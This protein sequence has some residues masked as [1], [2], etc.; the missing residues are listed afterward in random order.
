MK[1]IGA[2]AVIAAMLTP[3]VTMAVDEDLASLT[4]ESMSNKRIT[5]LLDKLGTEVVGGDGHW[6]LLVGGRTVIVVAQES[7]GRVRIIS[8]VTATDAL[9][10]EQLLGVM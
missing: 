1:H 3:F 4:R 8:P 9:S 6:Q 7:T 2:L 10:D 5:A